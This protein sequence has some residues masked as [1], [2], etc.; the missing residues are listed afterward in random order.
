[1]I[2][3]SMKNASYRKFNFTQNCKQIGFSENEHLQWHIFSLFRTYKHQ[4]STDIHITL[5]I[6]FQIVKSKRIVEQNPT[7]NQLETEELLKK[8][9]SQTR[10]SSDFQTKIQESYRTIGYNFPCIILSCTA[11]QIAFS[12]LKKCIRSLNP[13]ETAH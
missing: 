2:F 6:T 8:S 10:D 11:Y 5:R 12:N 1:M 4:A 9:N 7:L 3:L 13:S